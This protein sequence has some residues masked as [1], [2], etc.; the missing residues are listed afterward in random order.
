MYTFWKKFSE[1]GHSS[2][3]VIRLSSTLH[4]LVEKF[5]VV[6]EMFCYIFC[7]CLFFLLVQV[8]L[9]LGKKKWRPSQISQ[10][11]NSPTR[12]ALMCSSSRHLTRNAIPWNLSN[13]RPAWDPPCWSGK[14]PWTGKSRVHF[15]EL[16]C[17]PAPSSFL[18]LHGVETSRGGPRLAC[19]LQA[20][21][22][23][24]FNLWGPWPADPVTWL[25]NPHFFPISL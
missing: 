16:L 10:S 4:T 19:Y 7:L 9:F 6:N 17:L 5:L 25:W 18:S 22:P 2:H 8:M 24:Q 20:S 14:L 15:T 12:V 21:N 11:I 1:T 3:L 23:Y 13:Q